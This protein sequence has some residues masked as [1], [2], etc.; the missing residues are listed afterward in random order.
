LLGA[1]LLLGLVVNPRSA[2]ALPTYAQ[3]ELKECGYRHVNPA[4]GGVL[5]A[6]GKA[7]LTNGRAFNNTK[8]APPST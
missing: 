4:G 6:R 7:C 5:N 8:H 1:V 2:A 3:K